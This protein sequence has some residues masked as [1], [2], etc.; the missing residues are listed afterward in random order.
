M[1]VW[2]MQPNAAGILVK[3][4]VLE[5]LREVNPESIHGDGGRS[6]KAAAGLLPRSHGAVYSGD[7][8]CQGHEITAVQSKL[9]NFA[10]AD[11]ARRLSTLSLHL[12]G[13]GHYADLGDL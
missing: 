1:L 3:R 2:H 9:R 10:G 5:K 13:L 4:A 6:R 12:R 8:H 11:Q 7:E